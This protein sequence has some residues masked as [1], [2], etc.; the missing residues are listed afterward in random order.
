MDELKICHR[1]IQARFRLCYMLE[2]SINPT[3]PDL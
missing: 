2:K 1:R 3:E